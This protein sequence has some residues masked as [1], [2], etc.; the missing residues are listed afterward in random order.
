MEIYLENSQGFFLT[1]R[2]CVTII[3]RPDNM[4][5]HTDLN[6]LKN[7]IISIKKAAKTAGKAGV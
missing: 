4:T 6:D 2:S 1:D 5:I 7:G 3:R